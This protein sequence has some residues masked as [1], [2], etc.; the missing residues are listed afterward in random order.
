MP[1]S[2]EKLTNPGSSKPRES[3][4]DP[5]INPKPRNRIETDSELL[6]SPETPKNRTTC[7]NTAMKNDEKQ[8]NTEIQKPTE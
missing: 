7:A 5:D 1:G 2:Q 4:D 6:D 8:D 3:W